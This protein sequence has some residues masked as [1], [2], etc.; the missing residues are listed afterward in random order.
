MTEEKKTSK[1]Q[2]SQYGLLAFIPLI[3]FLA[4]FIGSGIYFTASGTVER[5]WSQMPRQTA[6][7]A[8]VIVACLMCRKISVNKKID[9]FIESAS[10]PGIIMMV[11]IF[12]LAG[13]FSGMCKAMGASSSIV[14]LGLSLLPSRFVLPGIFLLSAIVATAMGS[15]S[16]TLAVIAPVA[17]GVAQGLGASV[18]LYFA[19]CWGGCL[20]GDNL[21]II[22]DT[23][24]AACS[25][26]GCEMKDKF[27]MNF[28]IALPAAIVTMVVYF[29]VG[30]SGEITGDL[31]YNILLV[32]PYFYVLIAAIA[33]MNVYVVL[34]SGIVLAAVIGIAT[35]NI[36]LIGVASAVGSGMEGMMSMSVLAMLIAGLIG[37]VEMYGGIE[38][39]MTTIEKHIKTRKGAEYSIGIL[40]AL[41][42]TALLV[43]TLTIV[44]EAPLTKRLCDKYGIA[45]K[46]N[47]SLMD[48]FACI[49]LGFIPHAN[50]LLTLNGF[51]P[52]LNPLGVIGHQY[53]CM[54]FLV[55]VIITIQL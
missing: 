17:M 55:A 14:N 50:Y 46:R 24:I 37:I 28:A 36:S 23:T 39:L 25:G 5:P 52:D 32:I 27:R 13:A 43:N 48:M 6:V 51:Y 42:D 10:R 3:V 45:A 19:A 44:I 7:F 26:A 30:G 22:S 2:K 12:L 21:S 53:Y 11:I 38:W 20:F 35:G 9:K 33:G 54:F 47:A 31:S 29:I 16:G 41:L 1:E 18:E 4:L 8:G 40:S 15:S 34:T 49:F